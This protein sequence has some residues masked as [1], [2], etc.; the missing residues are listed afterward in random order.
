MENVHV[1]RTVGLNLV[2]TNPILH[3]VLLMC[4]GWNPQRKQHNLLI[5]PNALAD[6]YTGRLEHVILYVKTYTTHLPKYTRVI[7]EV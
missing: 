7:H 3:T 5:V 6:I 1:W 4:L 2:M